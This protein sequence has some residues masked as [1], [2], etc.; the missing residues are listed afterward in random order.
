MPVRLRRPRWDPHRLRGER[1]QTGLASRAFRGARRRSLE[2]HHWISSEG[3]C[4]RQIS[5]RVV[6]AKAERKM[7][8]AVAAPDQEGKAKTR[9][10]EI[11]RRG[12]AVGL[13]CD[14]A[15]AA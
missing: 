10:R 14:A 15:T 5:K 11:T 8:D 4:K 7:P 3:F 12:L 6:A 9:P 1:R 13:V 2:R